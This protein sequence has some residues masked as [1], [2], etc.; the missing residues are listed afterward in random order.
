[1]CGGHTVL[2]PQQ[3]AAIAKWS[4]MIEV[5]GETKGWTPSPPS[6]PGPKWLPF[7][8][9]TGELAFRFRD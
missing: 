6:D 3:H 5:D 8:V 4:S 2:T 1:M 9:D 7:R